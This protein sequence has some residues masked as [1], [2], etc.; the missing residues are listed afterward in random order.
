MTARCSALA[1]VFRLVNCRA[2][3]GG[4]A[5]RCSALA[6]VFLFLLDDFSSFDSLLLLNCLAFAYMNT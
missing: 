4:M 3:G 6:V 5:A 2:I 1:A